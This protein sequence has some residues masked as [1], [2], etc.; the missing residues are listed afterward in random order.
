MDGVV[1]SVGSDVGSS[2]G[3]LDLVTVGGAD[4]AFD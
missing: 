3:E 1:D 4:G 2:E